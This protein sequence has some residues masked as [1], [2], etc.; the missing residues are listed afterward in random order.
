MIGKLETDYLKTSNFYFQLQTIN[1]V[2]RLLYSASFYF[3]EMPVNMIYTFI[4]IYR[5]LSKCTFIV[6][7]IF[8]FWYHVVLSIRYDLPDAIPDGSLQRA[9]ENVLSM[10]KE[11][12]N[13]PF[14]AD[15][16][17]ERH[18]KVVYFDF[19]GFFM[20]VYTHR[21][22][23]ILNS[24]TMATVLLTLWSSTGKRRGRNGGGNV[25]VVVV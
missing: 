7:F 14:L 22:G 8:Y 1:S 23:L 12:A 10:I 21:V 11:I 18:G 25:D 20:V 16:G 4:F 2:Y 17:E 5:L 19:I 6:L 3:L 24:V 15:P 9:G 13:S